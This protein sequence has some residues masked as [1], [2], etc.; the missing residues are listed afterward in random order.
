M[1]IGQRLLKII[2]LYF[3]LY[4]IGKGGMSKSYMAGG[5]LIISNSWSCNQVFT[6]LLD[7][8]VS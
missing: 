8:N 2:V 7:G 1:M 4:K 5:K 6:C 3:M